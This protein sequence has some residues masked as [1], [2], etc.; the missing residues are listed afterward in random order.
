MRVIISRV[1]NYLK[2]SGVKLPIK[3]WHEAFLGVEITLW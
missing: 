2:F 1:L 3:T